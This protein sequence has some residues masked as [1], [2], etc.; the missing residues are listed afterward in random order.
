MN[1]LVRINLVLAATLGLAALVLG[2]GCWSLLQANAK[3]EVM[4]EAGLRAAS[5][6]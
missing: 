4:R 6:G 1:L 5:R 2:F 3:H